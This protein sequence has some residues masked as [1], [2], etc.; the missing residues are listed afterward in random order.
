MLIYTFSRD[1]IYQLIR[2][3]KSGAIVE[4]VCS[5]KNQ[6]ENTGSTQTR[7]KCE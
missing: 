1:Y 6:E 2:T 5:I 7:I 3:Y 4:N